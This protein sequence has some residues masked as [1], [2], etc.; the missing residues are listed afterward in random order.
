[1]K[2]KRLVTSVLL[3]IMI[4]GSQ[5]GLVTAADGNSNDRLTAEQMQNATIVLDGLPSSREGLEGPVFRLANCNLSARENPCYFTV[6]GG[7]NFVSRSYK[8]RGLSSPTPSNA[9]SFNATITC[10]ITVYSVIGIPGA[11]LQENINVTFWTANERTPLTMNWGDLAGTTT[12]LPYWSWS[13]LSGPTPN[14]SYGTY[15]PQSGTAFANA[16]G[17]VVYAPPP[18]LSG[19]NTVYATHF[20]ANGGGW[21]CS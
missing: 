4:L 14:P 3:V 7:G 1:M 15:V 21:W 9:A 18:P 19:S 11:R 10:G 20:T 8:S 2:T 12:Y 16:S 13:N 6:E 17:M 5:A